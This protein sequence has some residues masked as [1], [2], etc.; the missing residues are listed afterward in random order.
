MNRRFNFIPAAP[1]QRPDRT[2]GSP[3]L[4]DHLTQIARRNPQ[5]QN[6]DLFALHFLHDDLF[7]LS[8][9]A[10]AISSINSFIPAMDGV[11]SCDSQCSSSRGAVQRY[12]GGRLFGAAG[13]LLRAAAATVSDGCAP[14]FIQ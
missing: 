11:P 6:G 2:R 4:A 3:L 8:T 10:L 5:F 13:F 9:R 14:F 1:K 7:R 12:L